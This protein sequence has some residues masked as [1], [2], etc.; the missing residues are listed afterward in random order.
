MH[1]GQH[2]R[3]LLIAHIILAAR[4]CGSVSAVLSAEF[5]RQLQQAEAAQE[6][7]LEPLVG[8]DSSIIALSPKAKLANGDGDVS[9]IGNCQP[10]A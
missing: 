5:E 7:R 6:K 4:L 1:L 9:T 3:L 8:P 10:R 2:K